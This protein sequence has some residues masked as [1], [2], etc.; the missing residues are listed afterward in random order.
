MG[1]GGRRLG[2]QSPRRPVSRR[3]RVGQEQAGG[4][5]PRA[6]SRL[7]DDRSSPRVCSAERE[8]GKLEDQER[9]GSRAVTCHS[10]TATATALLGR[11]PWAGGRL[12][13]IKGTTATTTTTTITITTTHP[14]TY[15]RRRRHRH[16]RP[17]APQPSRRGRCVAGGDRWLHRLGCFG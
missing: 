13:D 9:L 11:E 7:A 6:G 17:R 15:T 16:L 12:K 5:A 14:S 3:G 8:R 10:T 1:H 4:R 2:G